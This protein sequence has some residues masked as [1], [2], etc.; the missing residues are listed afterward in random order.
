M[1]PVVGRCLLCDAETSVHGYAEFGGPVYLCGDCT[2]ERLGAFL[3]GLLDNLL[4]TPPG[5]LYRHYEREA[6]QFLV[7]YWRAAAAN[8]SD[9]R[10]PV[11]LANSAENPANPADS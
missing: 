7:G 3:A 4:S 1:P 10:G 8:I 6:Q 9:N 2:G 11:A 5:A